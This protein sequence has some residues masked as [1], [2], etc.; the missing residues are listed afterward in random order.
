[1]DF[2]LLKS[3]NNNLLLKKRSAPLRKFEGG[4]G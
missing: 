4:I 1:M 2:S 3:F